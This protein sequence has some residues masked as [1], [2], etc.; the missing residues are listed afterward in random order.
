MVC[1]EGWIDWKAKPSF[2]K[3]KVCYQRSAW[4]KGGGERRKKGGGGGRGLEKKLDSKPMNDILTY[5]ILSCIDIQ[6]SL[7]G[8]GLQLKVWRVTGWGKS[9]W[10]VRHIE[11]LKDDVVICTHMQHALTLSKAFGPTLFK[12]F[13]PTTSPPN[14]LRIPRSYTGKTETLISIQT[15]TGYT[16]SHFRVL[17]RVVPAIL[18]LFSPYNHN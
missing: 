13:F 8:D 9:S 11:Y 15:T 14:C 7:R 6:K 1:H 3:H 4:G 16:I 18:L 5:S 17:T 12:Y 10:S 2:W